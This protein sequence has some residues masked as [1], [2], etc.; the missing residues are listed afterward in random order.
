MLSTDSFSTDGRRLVLA[1]D[2]HRA[3]VWD[4]D[5]GK[6]LGESITHRDNVTAAGFCADG[7]RVFTAS[8]DGSLRFGDGET[9]KPV[10]APIKHPKG[11]SGAALGASGN[12]AGS[13]V[14]TVCDDFNARLWSVESG[15]AIGR[16]MAHR[17][18][19][20]SAAFSASGRQV[21]TAS[22]DQ[23][24][25][26]WDAA[27]GDAVGN[28]LKHP[29]AVKAAGFGAGDEWVWT[30]AADSVVR[31]WAVRTQ[32]LLSD[33]IR[34]EGLLAADM[35]A[36]G[37]LLATA[38]MDKTVRLWDAASGRAVLEPLLHGG[39]V[40]DVG[41]G[42]PDGSL[43]VTAD[44][45]GRACVWFTDT[46]K[47]VGDPLRHKSSVLEA[48]FDLA[49]ERV[50]TLSADRAARL[51]EVKTGRLIGQPMRL[52]ADVADD[53]QRTDDTL[54][55]AT[56]VRIGGERLV[57]VAGI[58]GIFTPI[59]SAS[60]QPLGT[61]ERQNL[62]AIIDQL[63]REVGEVQSRNLK[64]SAD[65]ALLRE[66]PAAP[67]DFASGVQ[68]SLDELQQRMSTMRNSTSNFAVRDF[69][70]DA[71]VFVQVS[72][73]GSIEYR[74]VQPG[75]K[76]EPQ[77]L[78]KLSLQVVPLPKDNLA[79][80]WTPN[81]FQPELPI[82]ALPEVTTESARQLEAAGL[83]S[84]GEFLQVGTRARAQ[85]YLEALLGVQRVRLALWAQQASLLTLRGVTGVAALLL[86]D[87]GLSR[88]D[89]LAGLTADALV[90]GYEAA[91]ARRT[92]LQAPPLD[93][94]LAELW[95]RA[96]RQYLGLPEIETTPPPTPPAP[97]PPL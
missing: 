78:S 13:V 87:A 88:L 72:P 8:A 95:I 6:P 15:D 25:Q 28:A 59:T 26:L 61:D 93:T 55:N 27:T 58:T 64:L 9:G 73:M 96:A 80:V 66:R 62:R 19:I 34:H 51:W 1:S 97:P 63:K 82:S 17:A 89:L 44:E 48:N 76:V 32:K 45:A 53:P 35:H 81:L 38:G 4:A 30:M 67:D 79:G 41:F 36:Q 74:F 24:A 47:P 23:T 2:D 54:N 5:S 68:Q 65:M 37:K 69:K 46:G 90:A 43:L 3:R 11:L 83:F 16:A 75:D 84:I 70:L 85:A 52:G 12:V 22:D 71:S 49:G 31:V 20:R 29:V 91:R 94:V 50:L 56:L 60:D 42:G 10:G 57:T 7:K 33:S 18:A 40:L 86:I 92:D 14:V 39:A 21:V 77:S